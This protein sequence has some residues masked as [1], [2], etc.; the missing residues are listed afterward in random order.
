MS[1]PLWSPTNCQRTHVD[2]TNGS[3][4]GWL[5]LG[6][7]GLAEALLLAGFPAG[8]VAHVRDL[9]TRAREVFEMLDVPNAVW[10]AR[11]A[12]VLDLHDDDAVRDSIAKLQLADLYLSCALAA[13]HPAALKLFERLMVPQIDRALR[14][15]A[16]GTDE[17][18]ELRQRVRVRVL[19]ST[20][21]EPAKVAQYSG[22]GSLSGWIRTVAARVAINTRRDTQSHTD[23]DKIPE[24]GLTETPEFSCLRQEHRAV[25]MDC[26]RNAFAQLTS[27]ERAI[28]RLNYG[29]QMTAVALARSYS[30]HESTMS[31]WLASARSTM[32]INFET[33][34]ADALGENGSI[35]DLLKV[36][37][38]RLDMSL[39]SLF[40]TQKAS[41]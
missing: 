12:A 22:R 31:R 24:V 23:L 1:P 18:D 14:S 2:D 16:L 19:V 10:A 33:L 15:F 38:S 6:P 36:I 9:S 37:Q 34:A 20:A 4:Y 28:V 32:A 39:H 5:G 3:V 40:A 27:R 13:H 11:L 26:L 29:S 8:S 30:V 21:D 35:G 7:G 41:A 17:R 25:F